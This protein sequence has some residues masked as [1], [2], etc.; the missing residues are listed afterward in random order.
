MR[1]SGWPST[2][3]VMKIER[4]E[5]THH[6]L[7]LDPP[8][9]ASWDPRPRER[10]P[11][12]VVRVHDDAGHVGIGSGDDMAGF[13]AHASLFVGEDPLD[14]DRHAQ[15]L[16]NLDFL[17]ARP[18]PLDVALWDL[19]GHITGEPIWRMVGGE[20]RRMRP[21]ASSA[22][23]REPA[24]MV[25][26]AERARDAGFGA[27]KL[28][29][30]RPS[31]DDDLE[32]VRSVRRA[33]GDTL[34]LMVDCN[35]GWRMP[36]DVRPPWKVGQALR[37]AREL[38]ELGVRW[39][40]EPLHRGDYGGMARLRR[41]GGVAIAG[42]ELTRE[43]HEFEVLLER[44]CLDVFQ[45]DVVCCLGFA[46][47]REL[48]ARVRERGHIFTPHTWGNGIGLVANLHLTAG[49]GGAPWLEVP[50]DPPEWTAAR[51]DFP[52]RAP[53]EP[54]ADGW[55]ALSDAPG[56]GIE[57]DEERLQATRSERATY[58]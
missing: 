37:V 54:D 41:E 2:L 33:L 29:F 26:V 5:I 32:A 11:A 40:E 45:P 9:P 18:W 21:Y 8:F 17:G 56:L 27:L 24:E 13:E 28:R 35:Q 6:Q 46:A 57:L 49:T 42:G 38:A 43:R 55:L 25:G 34:E 22:V 44:D 10:F 47:L 1:W 53:V 50:W 12:T 52:L 58:R 16:A 48:A 39:M 20:S 30:G 15:V 3:P 4:I 19:A 14:L 23:L 31:L 7:A 36:W 51:R